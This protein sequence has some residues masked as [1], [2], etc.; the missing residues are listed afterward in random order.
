M[1][2]LAKKKMWKIIPLLLLLI[3]TGT[4]IYMATLS[5]WMEKLDTRI[6]CQDTICPGTEGSIRVIVLDHNGLKPVKD[7][8][9][10][11]LLSVKNREYNLF[12]G[13]SDS[14]GTLDS[15]FK[16]PGEL[17]EGEG[18]LIVTVASSLGNDRIVEK[19]KICRSYRIL[20]TTDKPVYQPGQ[21]IHIRALTM[22]NETLSPA[23]RKSATIEVE[24]GKGNKLFR[25]IDKQTSDYGIISTDFILARE[26]EPGD[27]RIRAIAG[28]NQ[29]EITVQVKSYVLPK[30]KVTFTPDK[31]FY[32]PGEIVKGEVKADYFFGKPVSGARVRVEI[33]SYD[34]QFNKFTD[35]EGKTD[36]KG[37]FKFEEGLQS[38]LAG[39]PLEG[40]KGIVRFTVEVTD[41]AEHK[42]IIYHTLF[43]SKDTVMITVIPESSDIV[44]GVENIIYLVTS[45][46]DG[47]PAKTRVN[48]SL[49]QK[50][51]EL[52]TSQLGIAE[53]TVKPEWIG[54]NI[55]INASDG[56]GNSG[57]LDYT[58]VSNQ[59]PETLLLRTDR[60]VYKDGDKVKLEIFSLTSG[61]IY[62]DIVKNRQTRL[63]KTLIVKDKKA[64]M[65][66]PLTYDL[67][68]TLQVN[69]Y[70]LKRDGNFTRDTRTIYV[71]G[72]KDLSIKVTSDKDTY[73][74][75]S[76][77]EIIF[78]VKDKEGNPV[79]A[80]L[81]ISVVD[82]SVFALAGREAGLEKIYFT[83]EEELLKPKVEICRHYID[84][85]KEELVN[86]KQVEKTQ[87]TGK[88][89][90]STIPEEPYGIIVNTYPERL[91]KILAL[92]RQYFHYL[93]VVGLM[94]SIL[95]LIFSPLGLL[96]LTV[97]NN[98]LKGKDINRYLPVNNDNF[99]ALFIYL[100][101]LFLVILSPFSGGLLA[102]IILQ[103]VNWYQTEKLI[104]IICTVGPLIAG[105]VIYILKLNEKTRLP[106][107][108][109]LNTLRASFLLAQVFIAG[110]IINAFILTS[111]AIVETDRIA[112]IPIFM[113]LNMVLISSFLMIIMTLYST[114]SHTS[115]PVK[116]PLWK[117]IGTLLWT[118]GSAIAIMAVIIIIIAP[119]FL[120]AR[121]QG[122]PPGTLSSTN[123]ITSFSND[124]YNY[125]LS[126]MD[127]ANLKS[128]SVNEQQVKDE[129]RNKIPEKLPTYLRQYFPETMYFNPELITDTKGEGKLKLPIADS[130]TTWRMGVSASS[131]KGETGGTDYPVRVFQDFFID[132][133][134]PLNLI[135]GD[136]VSIP[137]AVYNYLSEKQVIE[138]KAEKSDWFT[139]LCN[140]EQKLSLGPNDVSVVYYPI[141]VKDIGKQKFTLYAKT[142]KMT[143]AIT[144]DV[145]II[146]E[147]KE[148]R[149]SENGWLKEP[150]ICELKIPVNSISKSYDM[151]VKIYPGMFSQLI[152]GLDSMLRMPYGCFEQTT[153]VTYPNIMVLDYMK[154]SG[155]ITPDIQMKAEYYINL[156]YQRL[157][158]FE[159]PG[160]G[161][162]LYGNAPASQWLTA[163]GLMEMTD[164]NKVYPIDENIIER[165]KNW[166]L[167]HQQSDG[168]WKASGGYHSWTTGKSKN[169]NLI[170]TAIIARAL[171]ETGYKG[172][173][174][175]RAINYIK[176]NMNSE[177]DSYTLALIANLLVY[178][179]PDKEATKNLL[180]Q[181]YE[182]RI[183]DKGKV[184]WITE[185]GT[186]TQ[187][188]GLTASIETT[189]LVTQ[190]FLKKGVYGDSVEKSLKF[191]ATSKDS[192]GTWH[193]TQATVLSLQTLILAMKTAMGKNNSGNIVDGQ[194]AGVIKITPEE[195]DIV[196][197]LDLKSYIRKGN[198]KVELLPEGD[199][200]CMYQI[201]YS[202][203]MPWSFVEKVESP[204]N[205]SIEYDRTVLKRNDLIYGKVYICNK[206]I[207]S[208]ETVIIGIGIPPGFEV[209]TDKFETLLKQKKIERFDITGRQ[210]I[211]YLSRME[212]GKDFSFS[213]G[214]RAK[215]PIKI[216]TPLSEV[217]EYYNANTRG[218]ALP[219]K[220]EVKM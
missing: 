103:R 56:L 186:I 113:V 77:G 21:T 208:G 121:A 189:A 83:L 109:A 139:F 93:H 191:L 158:G 115:K 182:T 108:K 129:I 104:G 157:V 188:Y 153:S 126:S 50:E 125:G 61:N 177:K 204:I 185:G 95:I 136:E 40:G 202:Y 57:T 25:T 64:K 116:L 106:A 130:I 163:Y 147:G 165:S 16:I 42:E 24:D 141:Q 214:L 4:T 117:K 8:D 124:E 111:T 94:S 26:A 210:I 1:E 144:K 91:E 146:P 203:Y 138:L 152:E 195:S 119:N 89:A 75:G 73:R 59:N 105:S 85:V 70:R 3:L 55:K 39:Q 154:S 5:K 183:E 82:E 174:M 53:F 6:L 102:F 33:A 169:L 175:D 212:P 160:G 123:R 90:F 74:P 206:G 38:Y 132:L 32:R 198:F 71:E 179:E 143:D 112:G 131:S 164:M 162:S 216:T 140:P 67:V 101:G 98:Y 193:S 133:D 86:T 58:I 170:E 137:V 9:I 120:K 2:T 41:K 151:W 66:I 76:T 176:T 134:L 52:E 197:L 23:G 215:F 155:K 167:K 207:K 168:S 69:A 187:S 46:P 194:E 35:I 45:Y 213:Y 62:I 196:K 19:I 47:T 114:L 142:Q 211:V 173:A 150:V 78:Q 171:S 190:A 148:F 28:G 219:E 48:I 22:E 184:Y 31:K 99:V 72:S 128:L 145:T 135:R 81:G 205:I 100:A 178:K 166:L 180:T 29:S 65:E 92:Q 30:F 218:Y 80:A 7:A 79:S 12:S 18:N 11:V 54:T 43:V 156:G 122:T 217:Y 44:P 149:L 107:V 20:L 87:E 159:V 14:E 10:K 63:T 51:K 127:K 34:I 68:G 96:I 192:Y 13:K 201:I 49:L 97:Y 172:A 110:F 60:A 220:I 161:F 209:I 88:V 200:K 36:E 15:I 84:L 27:Y 118:G 17:E 199:I 37:N 181:L